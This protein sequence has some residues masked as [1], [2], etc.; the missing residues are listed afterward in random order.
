MAYGGKK[1]RR[2]NKLQSIYDP[3]DP[4]PRTLPNEVRAEWDDAFAKAHDVYQK[5]DLARRSA[6]RE[7][8]MRWRQTG[9][10]TWAR[11]RDGVCYWPKPMEIPMPASDLVG[12]GVLVEYVY[13]TRG[14]TLRA[15]ELDRSHPPILWWDEERK[16]LYAF[17][18][19]EYP[20]CRPIPEGMEEAQETYRRWHQRDPQ[21]YDDIDVP[22]VRI[23]AVGAADSLSY[24]SD[25]WNDT[26]PDTALRDAQEYIHE[27]WY[28][29]WTWQDRERD[30]RVIIIE[31]GE[32]D[33]HERGL[34]H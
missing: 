15:I 19:Q 26:N 29:V 20:A 7:V 27:H 18:H 30:P 8:Q 16:I 1:R 12:L 31:G 21:C 5:K 6:W 22:D 4:S 25:K 34:I 10:K 24:A 33:L 17:P 13:I 3:P 2:G 14:G 9:K 11:C 28:D 32:L 23:R